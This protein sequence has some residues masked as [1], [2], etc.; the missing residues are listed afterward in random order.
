M[1]QDKHFGGEPSAGQKLAIVM[2]EN[3]MCHGMAQQEDNGCS[4]LKFY[5]LKMLLVS[6]KA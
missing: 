2:I 4:T 1:V 3:Q 6:S 5:D